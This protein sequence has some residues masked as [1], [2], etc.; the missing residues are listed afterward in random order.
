MRPKDRTTIRSMTPTIGR[1]MTGIHP[2]PTVAHTV[3][4]TTLTDSTTGATHP[5][6]GRG[7]MTLAMIHTTGNI[8]A[9][10][11]RPRI[12]L[13][14]TR[15]RHRQ[16]LV[17]ATMARQ[18]ALATPPLLRA[19]GIRLRATAIRLRAMELH[20]QAT[21]RMAT[22]QRGMAR[23]ATPHRPTDPRRTLAMGH[24]RPPTPATA[25][26]RPPCHRHHRVPGQRHSNREGRAATLRT[27]APSRSPGQADVG[28]ASASGRNLQ[29]LL[30]PRSSSA[31]MPKSRQVRSASSHLRR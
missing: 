20:R 10:T 28:G 18:A 1:P 8:T 15:T 24:R 21:H 17:L 19:L 9:A 23:P 11:H 25:R 12:T 7:H 5:Q 4:T 30:K 26:Q 2:R 22:L 27:R 14:A 3:E 31:K 13:V 29:E 6:V 16:T